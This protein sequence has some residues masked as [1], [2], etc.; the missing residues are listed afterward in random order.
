MKYSKGV[1]SSDILKTPTNPSRTKTS[2]QTKVEKSKEKSPIVINPIMD[3]EM[4]SDS[5]DDIIYV[6]SDLDIDTMAPMKHIKKETKDVDIT[7]V[8]TEKG[9][10]DSVLKDVSRKTLK[11]LIQK[12]TKGRILCPL[13]CSSTFTTAHNMYLHVEHQVCQKKVEERKMIKCSFE[14]CGHKLVTESAM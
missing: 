14:N 6:G 4:K 11:S 1:H 3:D 12:D 9:S 10:R 8:K 13:K 5:D 2:S 7:K